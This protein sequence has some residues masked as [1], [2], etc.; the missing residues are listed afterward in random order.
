MNL[1]ST[2]EMKSNEAD[3]STPDERIDAVERAAVAGKEIAR[4]FH[5]AEAF[6]QTLAQ[7][8]EQR[9]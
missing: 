3:N 7:I 8:A 4:V 9:Q 5:L 1:I 6:E 2:K